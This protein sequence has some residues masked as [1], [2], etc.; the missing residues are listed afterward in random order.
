MRLVAPTTCSCNVLVRRPPDLVVRGAD[1]TPSGSTAPVAGAWPRAARAAP[2][3]RHPVTVA[4]GDRRRAGLR[5][6]G[7]VR[8]RRGPGER[9]RPR[10]A[11]RSGSTLTAGWS[12]RSRPATRASSRPLL[13]ALETVLAMLHGA[14]PGG[15]PGVR[16]PARR[17]ARRRAYRPR[18]RRRR[19]LRQPA[20]PPARRDPRVAPGAARRAAAG[21][22]DLAGTAGRRSRSTSPTPTARCAG[23]TCSAGFFVER[24]PGADGGGLGAVRAGVDLPARH[25]RRSRAARCPRRRDPEPLLAAMYGPGWRVPDPA[26]KFEKS[27]AAQRRFDA[28]FRGTRVNRAQ[29]GPPLR[30]GAAAAAVPAA[31]TT[32]PSACTSARTPTRGCSTS[33]AA[34]AATCAGWPSRAGRPSGSTTRRPR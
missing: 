30:P 26:F 4:L 22:R 2:R 9:G 11:R 33:A 7:P 24:P 23:S 10:R 12:R 19:R 18:Q 8:R 1:R 5:R 13:D 6:R 29:L 15:V 20:H 3:G 14:G 16:H 25:R 32:S 17:G 31:R 28:W 21:L 34:A 27:D